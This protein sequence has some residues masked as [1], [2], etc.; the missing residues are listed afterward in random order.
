M[1]A[2]ASRA[3][4]TSMGR[5][6]STKSFC[7]S[8]TSS[9]ARSASIA[10]MLFAPSPEHLKP[11]AREFAPVAVVRVAGAGRHRDDEVPLRPQLHVV[12]RDTGPQ[13]DRHL[14]VA[15]DARG[16]EHIDRIRHLIEADPTLGER[17]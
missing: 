16:H 7:M 15:T 17:R 3:A 1:P 4:G 11:D 13:E 5:P 9:A 2:I 6:S 8:M 10:H 12:A 14:L